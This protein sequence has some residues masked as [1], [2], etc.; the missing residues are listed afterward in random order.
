MA[1][2]GLTA[3]FAGFLM[4]ISLGI[5]LFKRFKENGLKWS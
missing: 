4:A 3:D 5:Y 2:I 1:I